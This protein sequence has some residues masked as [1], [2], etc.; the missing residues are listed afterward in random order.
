MD[1]N[2]DR[3]QEAFEKLQQI[4]GRLID[5]AVD[6]AELECSDEGLEVTYWRGDAGVG[7]VVSDSALASRVIG[8][9]VDEAD[10]EDRSSGV[11]AWTHQGQPYNIAVEEHERYGEHAYTLRLVEAK[12]KRA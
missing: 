6:A 3:A 7:T 1:A 10:L 11:I 2:H 12:S 5:N 9:I 8:L 4:L